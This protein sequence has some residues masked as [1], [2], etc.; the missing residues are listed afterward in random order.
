MAIRPI[1]GDIRGMKILVLERNF[2]DA[3]LIQDA[4]ISRGYDVHHFNDGRQ[5]IRYLENS[6]ADLLILDWSSGP[7]AGIEVLGWVRARMGVWMP[8]LFATNRTAEEEVVAAFEAGADEYMIKP[9]RREELVARVEALMRR[10]DSHAAQSHCSRIEFGCYSFDLRNGTIAVHGE[11][12]DTSP[13]EFE[14]ASLLFR[15]IDRIMPRHTLIRLLWGSDMNFFSRG[16][17][18]YVYRVRRKLRIGRE[19]GFR[20]RTVYSQGYCL[21]RCI[22]DQPSRSPMTKSIGLQ[23]VAGV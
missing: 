1:L 9:L 22:W 23:V 6:T 10:V 11:L 21:E 13:K 15:N 5:L 17:D 3:A 2:L 14:L 8:V 18:T 19:S 7:F 20:L 12:I 4:L 16:L